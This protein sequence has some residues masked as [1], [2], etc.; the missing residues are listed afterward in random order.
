MRKNVK[1]LTLIEV[2]I[3]VGIMVAVCLIL[4]PMFVRARQEAQRKGCEENLKQ[5]GKAFYSY[6]NMNGFAPFAWGPCAESPRRKDAMTSI[7]ELYPIYLQSASVFRCPASRNEPYF[8]TNLPLPALGRRLTPYEYSNRNHTLIDSSYGY[9]CRVYP[10]AVSNHLFMA[11]MDG[12]ANGIRN[13]ARGQNIL[14][15]DGAVQWKE[16]NYASNDPIDNIF[17]ED[18]W[19]AD[20]DSFISDN[21]SSLRPLDAAADEFNDLSISYDGYPYLHP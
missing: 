18:P 2:L 4:F 3:L 9:D 13:H 5:I 20:T 14:N 6:Q 7:A 15:V 19:H 16:T 10:A 12:S 17:I 8:R 1:S 21:T 11:D